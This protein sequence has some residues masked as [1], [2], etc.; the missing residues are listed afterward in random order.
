MS[1]RGQAGRRAGMQAGL[2]W[3]KQSMLSYGPFVLRNGHNDGHVH[4]YVHVRTCTCTCTHVHMHKHIRICICMLL[5]A[6]NMYK[7]TGQIYMCEH[8]II[9]MSSS[10]AKS[11]ATV[12]GAVTFSSTLNV[13][14]VSWN[15]GVSS[16]RSVILTVI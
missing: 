12:T 2:G 9:P 11:V 10:V 7:L 8:N 5:M 14:A 1:R 16:F 4:T 3:L 13:S 15:C 6:I